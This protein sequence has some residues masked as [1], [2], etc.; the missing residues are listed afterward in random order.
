MD[1]KRQRRRALGAGALVAS[2]LA[3]TAAAGAEWGPAP[4]AEPATAGARASPLVRAALGGEGAWEESLPGYRPGASA[5]AWFVDE[6]FDPEDALDSYVDEGGQVLGFV[7]P[8][9]AVDRAGRVAEALADRGWLGVPSGIEGCATFVKGEGACRWAMVSCADV[10][11][12]ASVV[13]QG[14][15]APAG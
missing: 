3:L 8:G 11:G 14:E 13:V 6:L 1:E 15:K 7:F 12:R 2:A 9:A 5:P 4:E 10:S